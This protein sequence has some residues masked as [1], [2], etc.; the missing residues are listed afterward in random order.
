MK[1]KK[2]RPSPNEYRLIYRING[3]E[4][5]STQYYSGFHSSEAL[6]SLAHAFR[7]D[8]I[9]GGKLEILEIEERKSF[10]RG[11]ECRKEEA[12]EQTKIPELDRE[13]DRIYFR[14]SN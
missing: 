11:W 7:K 14:L 2:G 5:K 9:H 3:A 1:K 6:E 13:G 12:V 8:R 4:Q 10:D